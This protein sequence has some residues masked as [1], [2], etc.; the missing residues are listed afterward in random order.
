[1]SSQNEK[2]FK[3]TKCEGFS[4]NSKEELTQHDLEHHPA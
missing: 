4:F 1:M 2:P 3:C